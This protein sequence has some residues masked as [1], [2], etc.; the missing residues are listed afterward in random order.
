M[1]VE[2]NA[3][4]FAE[5]RCPDHTEGI[6]GYNTIGLDGVNQQAVARVYGEGD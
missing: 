6:D 1:S 4:S 3:L 2:D 5:Q